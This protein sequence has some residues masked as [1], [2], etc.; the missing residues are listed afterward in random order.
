MDTVI[1]THGLTKYFSSKKVVDR[2]DLAVPRGAIYALL[3]DNG[4]GKSTTI[5][6]L[7]GL[8]HAD[9]GRASLLGMD[10]WADAIE[11]RHRVGYVPEKPRYYDWMTVAELGA[12]TAGF[13]RPGFGDRFLSLVARFHLEPRAKLS[14]LSKGGYA[15]VGLAL[16]LANEPEVL[17]LDEPTS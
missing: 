1:Q 12:F 6:M 14:T 10:C 16:A 5:R 15:R 8:W 7:T 2:L 9:A 17:I 3:G 4:A 11:L 13:H